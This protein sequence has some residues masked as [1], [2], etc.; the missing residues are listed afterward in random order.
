VTPPETVQRALHSDV[1]ANI[2]AL[3]AV[4]ANIAARRPTPVVMI[5]AISWAFRPIATR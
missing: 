5:P 4:L 1:H 3:D 2:Q